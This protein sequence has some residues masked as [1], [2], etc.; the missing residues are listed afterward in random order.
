M[1]APAYHETRAL[2]ARGPD[3]GSPDYATGFAHA[4]SGRVLP[5]AGSRSLNWELGASAGAIALI[6]ENAA[7]NRKSLDRC[8]KPA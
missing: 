1:E 3:M 4:F 7:A 8:A 2:A 6:D 5:P